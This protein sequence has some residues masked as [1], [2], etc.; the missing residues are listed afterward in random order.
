M[1]YVQRLC[2]LCAGKTKIEIGRNLDQHFSGTVECP[3]CKG[4]GFINIS[5]TFWGKPHSR[6]K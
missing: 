5:Y 6:L 4:K 2:F 3:I 1:A